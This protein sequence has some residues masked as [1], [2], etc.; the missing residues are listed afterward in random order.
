MGPRADEPLCLRSRGGVG[1]VRRVVPAHDPNSPT[2]P[3]QA[4]RGSS[5]GDAPTATLAVLALL[6]GFMPVALAMAGR[7]RA[8]AVEQALWASLIWSSVVAAILALGWFCSRRIVGIERV[9]RR[10]ARYVC[11]ASMCAAA[12]VYA[13]WIAGFAQGTTR[14]TPVGIPVEQDWCGERWAGV[15][16]GGYPPEFRIGARRTNL[17]DEYGLVVPGEQT[18]VPSSEGWQDFGWPI[19]IVQVRCQPDHLSYANFADLTEAAGRFEVRVVPVI[20]SIILLSILAATIDWMANS[21][22]SWFRARRGECITCGHPLLATQLRCAECGEAASR[23]ETT[24]SAL[25]RSK[26]SGT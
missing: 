24:L 19:R 9:P 16:G 22:R 12:G 7:Q 21:A 15:V 2:V 13:P 8:A 20:S 26:G 25:A 1:C 3:L 6:T 11:L 4:R 23:A 17:A 5:I 18:F 10:F 14:A